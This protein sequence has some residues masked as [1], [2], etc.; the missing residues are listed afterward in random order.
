MNR[1]SSKRNQRGGALS[2]LVSLL[3]LVALCTTVYL[4]RHPIMR[5]AAETWVVNEPAAKADAIV[6]LSDDNF[7]A[8]RAT[9]AAELFRQG[10]APIVVASGRKLRPSAGIVE[11]MTHDLIERGVPRENIV[12]V[13]HDAEST[14]EEAGV[15]SRFAADHHWTRL[16]IVTSNFHTR[17]ARYIFQK[18]VPAGMEISLASA[19]DGDFDPQRWW[20]NRKSTKEFMGELLGM[21]VALWELRNGNHTGAAPA[22]VT[23]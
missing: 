20:E 16:I 15:I 18:V 3:F 12:P 11:L 7:Y 4:A 17:R 1:T 14:R 9:H 5:F 8:D 10:V 22:K 13:A 23:P 6:V 19:R 21:V 2:T